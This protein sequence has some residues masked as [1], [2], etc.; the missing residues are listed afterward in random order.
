M[1]ENNKKADETSKVGKGRPTPARKQQELLRKKPLVGNRSPEAKKVAKTALR[2]ERTKAREGLANGEDRYLT[3]RDRGPQR[4]LVRDI[5]DSRFTLGELVLPALFLVIIVSSIR[6][7]DVA[8]DLYI[9]LGTLMTMW[10]LFI[11]IALDGFIIGK[12]AQKVSQARF[13]DKAEKGLRWYA[14]MRSIQMR[15]MRLPKPQIKRGTKIS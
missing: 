11:A 4:R 1:P 14:A 8:I 10:G 3:V 15:G 5:V 6:T 12:K 13:G 7:E 9:Q 2:A